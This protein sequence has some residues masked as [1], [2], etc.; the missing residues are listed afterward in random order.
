MVF[1]GSVQPAG[2]MPFAPTIPTTPFDHVSAPTAQMLRSL[3]NRASWRRSTDLAYAL[4]PMSL[5]VVVTFTQR[6]GF[7]GGGSLQH[8]R[9]IIDS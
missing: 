5:F 8:R 3:S 9:N 6:T 4:S 1:A 7:A 2:A